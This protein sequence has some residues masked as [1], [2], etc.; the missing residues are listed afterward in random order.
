[1]LWGFYSVVKII[2]LIRWLPALNKGNGLNPRP[3]IRKPFLASC[4]RGIQHEMDLKN[5]CH[6]IGGSLLGY[7]AA[8]KMFII[9]VG[10]HKKLLTRI[11]QLF[12]FL[13]S[14]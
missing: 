9:G 6:R 10:P 3:S 4:C 14:I 11:T 12:L 13:F 7:C 2:S 5:Y 1:M 8:Q